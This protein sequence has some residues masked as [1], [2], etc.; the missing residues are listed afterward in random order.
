VE[1]SLWTTTYI[2]TQV[3]KGVP[4][5]NRKIINTILYADDQILMATS[6]NELQTIAYYLNLTARKY[7]M[8][9]S[10]S[11]TI[12]MAMCGK[13]IQTVK[14][15]INDNPIEQVS[16]FKYLGYLISDCKTD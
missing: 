2:I 13:H 16:E 10:N 12:S 15:V 8:S 11:K 4:L 9:V 14:I 6:Q 1:F 5:T 7:K 3:N